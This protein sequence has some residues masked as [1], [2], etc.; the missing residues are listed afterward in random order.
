MRINY[1]MYKWGS[2]GFVFNF[3]PSIEYMQTG[4]NSLM[5]CWL[6][7]YFQITWGTKVIG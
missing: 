7:F 2:L 6:T 1:G 3:L 4:C 5:I